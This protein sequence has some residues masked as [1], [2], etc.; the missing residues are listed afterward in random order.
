MSKKA[1]KI[2]KSV[3]N[4]HTIQGGQKDGYKDSRLDKSK[5]WH[6]LGEEIENSRDK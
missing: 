4:F 2:G 6:P 5:K 1:R 3:K